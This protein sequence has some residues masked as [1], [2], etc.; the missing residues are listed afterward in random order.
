MRRR[1]LAIGPLGLAVTLACAGGMTDELRVPLDVVGCVAVP[2]AA[3]AWTCTGPRPSLR[4]EFARA[5]IEAGAT[6]VWWPSAWRKTQ[7]VDSV[8]LLADQTLQVRLT[9][10]SDGTTAT[11]EPVAEPYVAVAAA[12]APWFGVGFVDVSHQL[13]GAHCALFDG[14]SQM[15]VDGSVRGPHLE[16]G[17][18]WSYAGRWTLHDGEL[19]VRGLWSPEEHAPAADV[20]LSSVRGV[21]RNAGWVLLGASRAVGC[22]PAPN[23]IPDVSP[24]WVVVRDTGGGAAE[25][26]RVGRYLLDVLGPDVVT[27]TGSAAPEQMGVSVATHAGSFI[28]LNAPADRLLLDSL[29]GVLPSIARTTQPATQAPVEV[30]VGRAQ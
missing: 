12:T 2:G 16:Y 18:E 24:V 29:S 30:W 15:A 4:N 22:G 11:L 5:L 6:R 20:S 8:W 9:R 17:S 19:H 10:D 27:T 21:P 14:P 25:V 26:E 3:N 23:T 28:P 1:V 13:P 7:G